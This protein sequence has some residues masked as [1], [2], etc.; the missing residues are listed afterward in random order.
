MT[1]YQIQIHG[2]LD[3]RW[4]AMF[5]HFTITHKLLDDEQPITLMVGEV[6]DQAALYG[7]ISRLRNLGIELISVQPVGNDDD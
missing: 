6:S 2:H 3:Q 7:L 1:Q 4:E 5:P